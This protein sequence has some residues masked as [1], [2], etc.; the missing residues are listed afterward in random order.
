MFTRGIVSDRVQVG[1]TLVQVCRGPAPA[2]APASQGAVAVA[3]PH[4]PQHLTSPAPHTGTLKCLINN[5]LFFLLKE[6]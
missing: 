1:L 5:F 6:F 3:L 4:R 2:P